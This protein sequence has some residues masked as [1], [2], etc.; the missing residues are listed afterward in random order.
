MNRTKKTMPSI[1][2]TSGDDFG[3]CNILYYCIIYSDII[4]ITTIY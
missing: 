2:K 3:K 1:L 4:N